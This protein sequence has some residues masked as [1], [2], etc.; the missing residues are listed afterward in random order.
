MSEKS[1]HGSI[2]NLPVANLVAV[3]RCVNAEIFENIS[4]NPSQSRGVS[5]YRS[6]GLAPS[7][8]TSSLSSRAGMILHQ[9][10]ILVIGASGSLKTPPSN[11]LMASMMSVRSRH[12]QTASGEV[13][14]SPHGEDVAAELAK[15]SFIA[16]SGVDFELPNEFLNSNDHNSTELLKEAKKVRDFMTRNELKSSPWHIYRSVLPFTPPSSP[17]FKLYGHLSDPIRIFSIAGE[18]PGYS[19]P[20]SENTLNARKV[21][22]A[23]LPKLCEKANGSRTG[24][25]LMDE[26]EGINHKAEF[27]VP[28]IRNG[29]VTAAALSRDGHFIALGFGNGVI[30]VADIDHHQTTSQFQC[31]PPN[32]PAW[33]EFI[34]GSHQIATEDN[35]GNITVFSHGSPSVKVGT[36]P[37]GHCPPVTLVADNAS[38]IIRVPLNIDCRWYE[39]MVISYVSDEP[40]IHPLS[41]PRSITPVSRSTMPD[42]CTLGLSPEGCYVIVHDGHNLAIWSLE[43]RELVHFYVSG[44]TLPVSYN[45]CPRPHLISQT[46]TK[47]PLHLENGIPR[48]QSLMAGHDAD[49]SWLERLSHELSS[50]KPLSILIGRKRGKTPER[51]GTQTIWLNGKLELLLPPNYRPIILDRHQINS[52]RVWYGDR[53]LWNK[54]RLY[55][56]CANKDGTRFLVQ[57]RMQAPIVVDISQLV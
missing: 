6:V 56:P 35:D 5:R 10:W 9:L 16:L 18:F 31:N 24:K 30:E 17:L 34:C 43:T 14:T 26:T 45:T 37:S 46:K 57:G 27:L 36:L 42:C 23:E 38:F 21:M 47:I 15:L 7:L 25:T 8:G 32:P 48:A 54:N 4:V 19:I 49:L 50:E 53:M 2:T 1:P 55:L 41:P 22:E 33:I 51:R 13:R 3:A 11:S 29:I 20:L 39:N 40:S 12:L 44:S 52:Q 28:S